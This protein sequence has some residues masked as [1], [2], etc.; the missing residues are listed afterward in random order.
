MIFGQDVLPFIEN[1]SKQDYKGD[2]Q[3]WSLTQGTDNALYFANNRFL[4][5]YNGVKWEKY[6]LPHNTVIRSVFAYE[7]KIFSGSYNE[8]GY[9]KREKGKMNYY[10]LAPA[11]FFEKD[12]SEEVWKVF[13]WHGNI[14][15]QTFNEIY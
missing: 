9:W 13:E 2:N 4:L 10:S 12:R 3:I 5:R 14:Y 6:T 8:F 15:F 7:D 1:Y 11:N